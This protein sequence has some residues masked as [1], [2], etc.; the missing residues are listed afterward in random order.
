[1]WQVNGMRSRDLTPPPAP[2]A[3][4]SS[5]TPFWPLPP[6]RYPGELPDRA[7]VIVIGGGGG[8]G[9]RL[10]PL[11]LRGIDSVLLERSHL[12][13]GASGRN[14]GFLLAG[15]AANYAEAVRAFGRDRAR[16]L[17]QLTNE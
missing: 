17:W 11:G 13:A 14:A 12:A 16:E 5:A 8:G 6:E 2:G 4:A 15:V 3:R 10:P 1:M 7:D 9:G